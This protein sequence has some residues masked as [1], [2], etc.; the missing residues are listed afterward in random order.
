MK[1]NNCS[2]N[3]KKIDTGQRTFYTWLLNAKTPHR[4]GP[5]MRN[6]SPK[7]NRT[8]NTKVTETLS[9]APDC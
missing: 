4:T 7:T 8:K 3:D 2:G 1:D 9:V 5:W 6:Y